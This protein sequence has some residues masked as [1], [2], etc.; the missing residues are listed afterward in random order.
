MRV[1][2]QR[3]EGDGRLGAGMLRVLSVMFAALAAF[4]APSAR[5]ETYR[6]SYEAAVLGVV[7]L[8]TARYEVA[9]TPARYA[10]RA[11]VQTTGLARLFDRTEITA[12]STGSVSGTTIGWT[13]YDISHAYAQKFRRIRMDRAAGGITAAIDPSYGDMGRPAATRAQQNGSYDPLTAVF[14]LGRQI[15]A[16]R[17]CTGAVLVFDGRQ[18]YRLGVSPRAQG[19]FN[20][21]GYNGP[22][23]SCTLR[24][25]P[26]AGFSD[27]AELSNLPT[28][29]IWFALPQ[30]GGFA[31][32]LRLTVPTPL[33]QARLDLR[34]Y[35]R[36]S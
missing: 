8:G 10:V 6:L 33:G 30:G 32:P 13:R 27:N 16:A 15:G 36:L 9:A 25:E 14:V 21:G 5:A 2:Y 23:V 4:A 12:T 11:N 28:A 7:V 18:H 20:G 34:R 26:I 22:A 31:P 24:Y 1:F 17:A 29:E 19:T 3:L 35:E